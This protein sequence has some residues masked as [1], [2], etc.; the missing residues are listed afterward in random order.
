LEKFEKYG[1]LVTVASL[2]LVVVFSTEKYD[3]W[4]LMVTFLAG[5][6]GISF[7]KDGV[8][9]DWFSSFNASFISVVSV[10]T[11]LIA[12]NNIWKISE[13]FHCWITNQNIGISNHLLVV[14][15]V[16]LILSFWFKPRNA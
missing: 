1:V 12:A 2:L 13:P 15:I 14:I 8:S 7:L 11:G 9:F 5:Y 16:S 10:T 4:D 3:A 6:F